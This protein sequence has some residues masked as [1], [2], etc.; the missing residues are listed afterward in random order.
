MVNC[1]EDWR[2]NIAQ[3]CIL[4]TSYKPFRPTSQPSCPETNW[5]ASHAQGLSKRL[6]PSAEPETQA[7]QTMGGGGAGVG[8][9]GPQQIFA[10][11]AYKYMS[12]LLLSMIVTFHQIFNRV[13]YFCILNLFEG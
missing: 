8:L 4:V 11:Y 1:L 10:R 13:E 3:D 12:N 5:C 6:A 7:A 9:G 2:V